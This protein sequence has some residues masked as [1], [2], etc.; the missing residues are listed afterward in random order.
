MM[1]FEVITKIK[2]RCL[3][4]LLGCIVLLMAGCGVKDEAIIL[5][6]SGESAAEYPEPEAVEQVA[7]TVDSTVALSGSET[8]DRTQMV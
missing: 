6:P 7:E 1:F 2:Y 8:I 3:I 5:L 4:T